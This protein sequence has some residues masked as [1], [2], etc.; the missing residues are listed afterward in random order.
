MEE[1]RCFDCGCRLNVYFKPS[2]APHYHWYYCYDCME[3]EEKED[4]E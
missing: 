3:E 4:D 2:G 1:L